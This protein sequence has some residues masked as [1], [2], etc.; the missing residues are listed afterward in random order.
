[1]LNLKAYIY[2]KKERRDVG[3]VRRVAFW[4]KRREGLEGRSP[5]TSE[6]EQER[7]PFWPPCRSIPGERASYEPG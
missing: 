3:E 6:G 7:L 5:R 2:I 1:M 4:W